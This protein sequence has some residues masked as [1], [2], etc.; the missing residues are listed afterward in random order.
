MSRRPA[1]SSRG[2]PAYL[3]IPVSAVAV[4]SCLASPTDPSGHDLDAP[5]LGIA[6]DTLGWEVGEVWV[7][8]EV[9]PRHA[10]DVHVQWELVARTDNPFWSP[11]SLTLTGE[12][13]FTDAD[14]ARVW[15]NVPRA[16]DFELSVIAHDSRGRRVDG[17]LQIEAPRCTD[18]TRPSLICMPGAL[19]AAPD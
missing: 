12:E 13:V 7:R 18:P 14:T 10:G 19:P 2:W 1:S 11:S 15:G 16:Y 3:L 5:R 4:A 9:V 8:V 17:L 6:I